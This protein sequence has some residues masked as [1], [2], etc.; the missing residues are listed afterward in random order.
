MSYKAIL[1][2]SG[3]YKLEDMPEFK[4]DFILPD[5]MKNGPIDC[6][7]T[8]MDE[9]NNV[10]DYKIFMAPA[11]PKMITRMLNIH[12]LTCIKNSLPQ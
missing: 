10:L 3:V 5:S 6:R 1:L 2:H 7:I 12:L 11:S 9:E 8:V 4:G